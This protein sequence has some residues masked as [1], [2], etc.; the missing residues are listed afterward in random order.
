[1]RKN[2][3]ALGLDIDGTL[4]NSEKIVLQ[5]FMSPKSNTNAPIRVAMP[6][7]NGMSSFNQICFLDLK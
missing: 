7:R 3:K 6:I 1:M 2:Y 4:T 5:L